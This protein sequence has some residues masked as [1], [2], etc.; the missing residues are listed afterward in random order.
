VLL[1]AVLAAD[2]R[3]HWDEPLY[4]YMAAFFDRSAMLDPGHYGHAF[5]ASRILHLFFADLVFSLTGPG[6]LGMSLIAGAYTVLIVTALLLSRSAVRRL[7]G[8]GPELDLGT[9]LVLFAPGVL[10]LGGTTMPEVPGLFATILAWYA[11]L[12]TLEP[13][14]A[15]EWVRWALLAGGAA[16]VAL[17]TR[18]ALL[19]A[20]ATFGVTLLLFGGFRYD[21]RRVLLRGLV[22]AALAA[23]AFAGILWITGIELAAYL[24]AVGRAIDQRASLAVRLYAG[25]AQGGLLLAAV[26]LAFLYPRRDVARFFLVW[27]ILATGTIYTLLSDVETRYLLPNLPALHGLTCLAVGGLAPRLQRFRFGRPAAVALVGATIAVATLAQPILEHEVMAG[28]AERVIRRLDARYGG[29]AGYTLLTTWN[30]DFHYLRVAYPDHRILSVE[31]WEKGKLNEPLTGEEVEHFQGRLLR[32][33]KDLE[34]RPRPWLYYGFESNFALANL[35]R[36]A[37]QLP[38][39]L[40]AR[41]G[42]AIARGMVQNQFNSGWVRSDARFR[43]VPVLRIGHYRVDE[44]LPRP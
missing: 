44:V 20:C 16:A 5:Y 31:H 10:W 42:A 35:A 21:P 3:H 2:G 6:P 8:D 29:P 24:R 27:F 11:Y 40:G 23:L 7:I 22:I 39:A 13:A 4:L 28:D 26:P 19:V 30:T 33:A 32:D 38:G 14:R 37:G 43:F 17:C 34:R 36:T 41:A 9:A 1:W 18:N 25:L 12:R 15:S